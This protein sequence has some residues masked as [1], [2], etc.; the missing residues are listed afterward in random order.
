MEKPKPIKRSEFLLP[1][2]RDHHF[3]LL[4]AWKIKQ[5]L[6]R[7][8]DV[9]RIKKYVA[10]FWQS[11]M[12]QHFREEEEILFPPITDALVTRA[13]EEHGVISNL[14]QEIVT[15]NET[16]A[17]EKLKALSE[18]VDEH[19][20]YEERILFPH[21]E[22]QLP[23]HIKREIAEKLTKNESSETADDYPDEFWKR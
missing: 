3:S 13:I 23:D 22:R 12:E 2:S 15:P 4:F 8:V 5:G 16:A 21:L 9:E 11:H 17:T 10:Y 1:L 6:N 14:V 20:R 7:E 19:V 18:L